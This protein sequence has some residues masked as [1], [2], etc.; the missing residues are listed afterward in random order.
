MI[1]CN[2]I[3]IIICTPGSKDPG[4]KKTKVE[5]KLAGVALVQFGRNCKGSFEGCPIV[6]LDRQGNSLK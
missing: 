1:K 5:I 2:I 3:I 6:A 4:G